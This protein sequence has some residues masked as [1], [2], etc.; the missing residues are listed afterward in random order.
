MRGPEEFAQRKPRGVSLCRLSHVA[1]LLRALDDLQIVREFE[2]GA[3]IGTFRR[4][5][6]A[7]SRSLLAW[8]LGRRD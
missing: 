1:V 7:R 5:F 6:A 8:T 3:R 4:A 2:A